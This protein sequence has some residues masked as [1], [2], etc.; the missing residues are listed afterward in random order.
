METDTARKTTFDI[1]AID[2]VD[3]AQMEV[4]VNGRGTGWFWTFAGPGHERGQAQANRVARE[5]LHRQ[6]LKEQATTNGRKWKAEEKTPEEVRKENADFI[7]ER[8]LGWSETTLKGQPYPFSE[9]NARALL[10]DPQ[11]RT[12][13]QQAIEFIIEDSSFTQPSARS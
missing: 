7:V 8:L 1:S 9:E 6:R 2:T 10:M 12:L 4:M 11:K 13:M 5:D 3:T